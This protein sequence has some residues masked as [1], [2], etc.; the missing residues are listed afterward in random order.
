MILA[1]SVLITAALY[2]SSL[3]AIKHDLLDYNGIKLK[4]LVNSSVWM[5]VITT[6][7]AVGK[8]VVSG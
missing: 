8:L 7:V 4:V 2:F 1:W 5:M 3:M 6:F